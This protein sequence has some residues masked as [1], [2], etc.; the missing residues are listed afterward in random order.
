MWE[1]IVKNWRT[2]SVAIAAGTEILLRWF[3]INIIPG[4]LMLVI[5]ALVLLFAK[6]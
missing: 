2:S 5:T 1:R 3:G 4:E 6:D